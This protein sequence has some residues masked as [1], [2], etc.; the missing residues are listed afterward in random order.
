MTSSRTSSAADTPAV[1]PRIASDGPFA[2]LSALLAALT[3]LAATPAARAAVNTSPPAAPV[4][5]VFIHH[6]T[7]QAWLEDGHGQLGIALRDNNYFVSDTNYGWGPDSIGDS[8][9]IGHWWT[10]FRGPSSATYLTALY[11]ESDTHSSYSRL[12]A[13]P[14]GDNEIVMFKSCFP[15]SNLTGDASAAVPA[16]DVN[17]LK[18]LACGGPE[19]TV[20]NAKGI[21]ND[22]LPYFAAHQ[23]KLFVL[24]VSPPIQ[25]P[26]TPANGRAMADWLVDHW[27]QDAAYAHDNVFVFDF[28]NVL[29]SNGGSASVNDLDAET[30]NHHRVWNGAVQHKTDDG[31]NH[32]VYPSGGDDHPNTAGDRK[33]TAEFLPLLNNAY[34]TWKGIAGSD[35]TGPQAYA[36]RRAVVTRGKT[37]ALYYRVTDDQAAGCTVTIKVKTLGGRVVRTLRLG[38]QG[39]DTLRHA[40]FRCRLAKKTYR[41]FVYARD[42]SGNAQTRTGSNRLVVR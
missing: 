26:G 5:L 28:Y 7:G 16:I 37:A 35:T 36:P 34:N 29:T 39:C 1:S 14:G 31:V 18:G 17:P 2:L 22:L 19:F 27:L 15:N 20:A 38:L 10:W 30:G 6:S 41:F 40:H 13:D 8:T 9:D 12:D 11:S 21:Y 3:L 42:L 4:K 33:A 24:I 25:A 32:L 23:E